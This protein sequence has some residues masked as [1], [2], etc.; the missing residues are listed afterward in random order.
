MRTRFT[1][2]DYE[3]TPHDWRGE[4]VEGALVMAATPAP[5]H[6]YLL[7][8]L[9]ALL[10]GHL[11]GPERVI[12]SPA[13]VVIDDHNVYVPDLM[14]L[15]EN[16]GRPSPDWKIPTPLWV[17]EILSPSTARYD[18]DRKVPNYARAGVREAWLVAPRAREVE[19][20]DLVRGTRTLH[21]ETDTACSLSVP[22]FELPLKG[23]F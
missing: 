20:H 14:V 3:A 8:K 2:A 12:A 9:T 21:T 4:L 23:F 19:I 11:G 10:V 17:V 5:Y 6:G 22:G 16:A 7:T 13:D 15:P 18:R 1:R